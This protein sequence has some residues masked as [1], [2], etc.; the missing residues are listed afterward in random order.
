MTEVDEVGE[1]DEQRGGVRTRARN[2]Y[3]WVRWHAPEVTA[4]TASAAGAVTVSPW[5]ATVTAV[6]AARWWWA[7]RPRRRH[8]DRGRDAQRDTVTHARETA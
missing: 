2:A 6:V 3:G 1:R 7:D 4:V 5:C 8:G